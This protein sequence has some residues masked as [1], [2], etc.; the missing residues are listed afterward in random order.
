LSCTASRSVETQAHQFAAAY[1]MP[2]DDI[3]DQLPTTADWPA[4]FELKR[5]WQVRKLDDV[6]VIGVDRHQ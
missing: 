4:L 2:A 3:R 1:L 5:S 6:G